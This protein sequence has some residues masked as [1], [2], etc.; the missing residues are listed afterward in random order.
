MTSDPLNLP[1]IEV[2][3]DLTLEDFITQLEACR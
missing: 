1:R 3:G 2:G